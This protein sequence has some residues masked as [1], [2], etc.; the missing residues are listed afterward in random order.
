VYSSSIV[1]GPDGSRPTSGPAIRP[2]EMERVDQFY[3]ILAKVRIAISIVLWMYLFNS[4]CLYKKII[5]ILWF[6]HIAG[7]ARCYRNHFIP[8]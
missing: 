1:C 3:K 7:I 4:L 8:I 2:L 6:E 5:L